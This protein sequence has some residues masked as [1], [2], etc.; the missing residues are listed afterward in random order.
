[1]RKCDQW[2]CF[3]AIVCIVIELA[4]LHTVISRQL[5]LQIFDG[6]SFSFTDALNEDSLDDD[7]IEYFAQFE[8]PSEPDEEDMDD[9]FV[10]HHLNRQQ[11]DF[12]RRLEESG[13]QRSKRFNKKMNAQRQ[14]K[15][16]HAK[17]IKINSHNKQLYIHHRL[18]KIIELDA[19]SYHCIASSPP[20]PLF[21]PDALRSI[22]YQYRHSFAADR[23]SP[24]TY[25]R[26][27]K[28]SHEHNTDESQVITR[29]FREFA[30]NEYNFP[31]EPS[32]DDDMIN[33]LLDMQNRDV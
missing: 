28:R 6:L 11:L 27:S 19:P 18:A 24:W 16:K 9:L 33:F 10:E 31:D 8:C 32:F 22:V 21:S 12:A 25:I 20:V 7:D 29:Q 4:G 13:Y 23:S 5:S 26:A 15:T 3:L 30:I 1:M 17:S 14:I 2:L